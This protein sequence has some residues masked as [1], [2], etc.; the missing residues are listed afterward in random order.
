MQG[1]TLLI[2]IFGSALALMLPPAYALATYVATLLWYPDYLRVS[3]GTIDLSAGRI[4]VTMLLLRCL[5]SDKL[6][7]TFVWFA[8]DT[9]VSLALGIMA[10][11]Y[12]I[13]NESLSAA[14]ENRGGFLTDTWFAYLAARFIITDKDT[15]MRFI[16]TTGIILAP[17]AIHGIIEA[18]TGWQPFFQLTQFRRWRPSE[19]AKGD[20]ISTQA[21]W[22]LTRAIG[23]FSHPILFGECFAMFLPLIW[24]LRRHH[25]YWG[26][27]AYLLSAIAVIGAISSMSSGPWGMLMVVIFCLVLEKYKRW[28]KAILVLFVVLCILAEI[29]SNRPLYHV[30]LEYMNFGKG[31]WYQR[32]RLIDVAIEHID[33][34]WLAGYGGRDPGWGEAMGD[35]HTDCNNEFLLA[36]A[37]SGVLGIIA[38]CAVL[39]VAFRALARASK[40]TTDKELRS[41]YWSMGSMLVGVITAWQGVSFF[42]QI[43]ALFYCLLGITGSS[44]ALA[45]CAK[46][47]NRTVESISN[48]RSAL[49][50]SG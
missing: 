25:G 4:I 2:A 41:L 37:Y 36:G 5:F 40:E 49:P 35:K 15:L 42:G 10:V 17:L 31:D 24:A 29:G 45:K 11:V 33:E 50:Y 28:L 1:V 13:T 39:V 22:G 32:A 18:T 26:K 8:L 16:K 46:F 7:R 19:I 3:I 21:R 38:L 34:W 6:R 20:V 27:L 48:G 44:F 43:D 47:G 23:P 30:A 14:I 12:C 9:W